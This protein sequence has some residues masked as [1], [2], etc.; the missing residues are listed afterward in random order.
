MQTHPLATGAQPEQLDVSP[1]G[2]WL[3]VGNAADNTITLVDLAR[4][5]P[6]RSLPVGA[7][8]FG[9]LFSNAPFFAHP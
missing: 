7:G 6:V 8:N 4:V 5:V 1:D 2:A 3:A 9:I